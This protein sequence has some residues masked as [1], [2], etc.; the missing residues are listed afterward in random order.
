MGGYGAL[1]LSLKHPGVF[2]ALAAHAPPAVL[3]VAV[4]VTRDSVLAE[5]PGPPYD[6][7]PDAGW[8]SSLYF[9]RSGAFSPNLL[10][11]PY[12]VDFPLDEMGEIV[13]SVM[14][15]WRLNSPPHFAASHTP[16]SCPEIF[17]DCGTEDE[18]MEYPV[19]LRLLRLAGCTGT[20]LCVRR[21]CG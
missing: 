13:G 4:E 9:T 18:V 16:A 11:P 8:W 21:L 6:Y 3:D 7:R 20:T 2:R 15:R 17:F 19:N 12:S 5:Y 10:N 14:D 1:K